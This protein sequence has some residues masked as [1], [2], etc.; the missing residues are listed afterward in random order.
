MITGVGVGFEFGV[1]GVGVDLGGGAGMFLLQAVFGRCP[2]ALPAK[3][4]AVAHCLDGEGVGFSG[5]DVVSLVHEV[6]LCW[7]FFTRARHK[8]G[9]THSRCR[10]KDIR[11]IRTVEKKETNRGRDQR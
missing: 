11:D 3:V 8:T 4:P 10:G 2:A 5:K 1:V 6:V 9:R 7:V